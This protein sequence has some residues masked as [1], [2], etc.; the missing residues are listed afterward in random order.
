[1]GADDDTLSMMIN[2]SY[3]TPTIAGASFAKLDGGAG[4]DTINWAESIGADGQSLTLT[5]G[6]AVN[7]ENLTGS[8]YADTLTGDGNANVLSGGNGLDTLYGLGGNDTLYAG[9][10]TQYDND[11]L[12]G[13]AGD[14]SLGGN[15]GNNTLDGGTGKDIITSGSGSDTIVI[16]SGDGSTDIANADILTDFTDGT[17]VI[18]IDGL[19]YGDLTVQQG[20][21]ENSNHVIVKYGAEFLLVI[22]NVSVGNM[23]SPD[24]TPL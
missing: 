1:M 19:N 24:F 23:T 8:G 2:G 20:T 4:T 13:G 21:D 12:Y 5:T 17:D 6:G 15:A 18:G 3:G 7:F 14:D 16:R 10:S 22:Q 11:I 9:N